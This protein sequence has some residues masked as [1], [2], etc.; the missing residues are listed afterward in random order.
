MIYA[1]E[2]FNCKALCKCYHFKLS[3]LFIFTLCP[4]TLTLI[5]LGLTNPTLFNLGR[6]NGPGLW[7]FGS[8]EKGIRK[9]PVLCFH[10]E[11]KAGKLN[12]H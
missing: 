4:R 3:L 9:E 6:T 8:S 1:K 11:G 10:I 2:D 5:S 7:N 12:T